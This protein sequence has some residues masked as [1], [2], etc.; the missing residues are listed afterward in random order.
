MYKFN[1]L[2]LLLFISCKE[3]RKEDNRHN[4]YKEPSEKIFDI[5]ASKKLFFS[6]ENEDKSSFGFL[7]RDRDESSGPNSI[8]YYE[9][10]LYVTDPVHANVKRINVTS[11]EINSTLKLG[12]TNFDLCSLTE[13]KNEIFV[14]T[15]GNKAFKIDKSLNYIREFD[16]K[17]FKG[18]K[19]FF[20]TK[21]KL[22]IYINIKQ[23]KDFNFTLNTLTLDEVKLDFF[24]TEH[25][26]NYDEFIKTPYYPGN[27]NSRGIMYKIESSD[28]K[29]NLINQYGN[30][31]LK[32]NIPFFND[33]YEC[34]NLFFNKSVI[35]YFNISKKGILFTVL[36]Y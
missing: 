13:F 28:G 33:Y 11:G 34:D 22:E 23:D 1:V 5:R 26:F 16:L 17:N 35:T 27:N 10:Y 31:E 12:T 32:E 8:V 3:D 21:H 18:I 20:D 15:E 19:K 14:F 29:F 36:Y 25:F 9:D 6:F 30:F 24:G 2:I 4:L 7:K